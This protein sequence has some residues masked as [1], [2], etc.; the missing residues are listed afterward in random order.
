[1]RGAAGERGVGRV[2]SAGVGGAA[3]RLGLGVPAMK[4]RARAAALAIVATSATMATLAAASAP[5]AAALFVPALGRGTPL[6]GEV[7]LRGELRSSLDGSTF[8]AVTQQDQFPVLAG[9]PAARLGGLFDPGAGGLRVVEQDPA[10]HVY[11]LA[12]T[13]AEGRA[14]E[15]AGVT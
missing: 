12:P 1:A 10:R 4:R 6:S 7:V 2:R 8:D 9:A 15:E 13:G 3:A 11:R 14:C 5:A